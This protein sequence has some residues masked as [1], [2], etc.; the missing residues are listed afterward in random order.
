MDDIIKIRVLENEELIKKIYALEKEIRVL[1]Q[2]R[3][4]NTD[5]ISKHCIHCWV[6][7]EYGYSYGVASKICTKCNIIRD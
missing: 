2:K 6:R 7:Y 5:F 1:K 4:I 3:R